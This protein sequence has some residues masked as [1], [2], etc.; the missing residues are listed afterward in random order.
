MEVDDKI[1]MMENTDGAVLPN[2]IYKE[3]KRHAEKVSIGDGDIVL[4]KGPWDHAM[5]EHMAHHLNSL[6]KRSL[7]VVLPDSSL[8]FS[9]MPIR[10]FYDMLK[11]VEEEMG[12][13]PDTDG[14][15][16]D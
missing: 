4:L 15:C 13:T 6:K 10:A 11:A 9:T 8:N 12:I 5:V 14:V 7:I 2:E 1:K 16:D 3:V